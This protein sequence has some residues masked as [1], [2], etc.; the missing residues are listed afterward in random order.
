MGMGRKEIDPSSGTLQKAQ[1]SS[2][3]VSGLDA[4]VLNPLV[5][6]VEDKLQ[7]LLKIDLR[8]KVQF[9]AG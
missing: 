9:L 2:G 8:I 6:R 1:A 4:L 3:L 7:S 5:G